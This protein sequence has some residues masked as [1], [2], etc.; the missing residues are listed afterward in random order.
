[1]VRECIRAGKYHFSPIMIVEIPKSKG[2]TDEA[3][4]RSSTSPVTDRL[5]Q[6]ALSLMLVQLFDPIFSESS[7]L[8]HPA[9]SAN[10]SRPYRP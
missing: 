7:Y 5:I 8:Y 2:V 10:P 4:I 6:Q 1:M 9:R 3:A